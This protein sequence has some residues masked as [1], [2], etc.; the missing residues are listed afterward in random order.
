M[1]EKKFE[2]YDDPNKFA[3]EA[4]YVLNQNSAAC[5]GYQNFVVT[6]E[7][8]AALDEDQK[9]R[10]KHEYLSQL[11]KPKYI[12]GRTVLD[13]GGNSGYFCYLSLLNEATEA[14]CLDMDE[15]YLAVAG[16]SVY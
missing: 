8:I 4:K 14:T 15:K 5:F 12:S 16:Y 10:V 3:P 13:L 6:S 11:L 9:L 2:L 7:S 1:T